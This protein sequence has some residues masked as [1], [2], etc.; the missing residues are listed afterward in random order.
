MVALVAAEARGSHLDLSTMTV[1][2]NNRI[3]RILISSS[4]DLA[5]P[6]LDIQKKIRKLAYDHRIE[7]DPFLWEEETK[8][9]LKLGHGTP[10]QI[11]INE[12]LSN[13][14]A[15]TVVMFGE[16]I[17][18]PLIGKLPEVPAG[19]LEYWK[20]L[21]LTHPWPKDV[22][23]RQSLLDQGRFPLT[24]TVYELLIA[25]G[26]DSDDE[27]NRRLFVGYVADMPI[28][29]ETE[30]GDIKFN[31]Y[32]HFNQSEK[33]ATG[34]LKYGKWQKEYTQQIHGIINLQKALIESDYGSVLLRFDE[35]EKM[36]NT[37]ASLVCDELIKRESDKNKEAILKPDFSHYSL[38]DIALPDRAELRKKLK[39]E[40]Y[41]SGE[42]GRMLALKGPSG[43]GKSSL[44]QR[45]V[46]A[47][48]PNE[49]R[50]PIVM[51]VRPTDL[52]T[53]TEATPLMRLLGAVAERLDAEGVQTLGPQRNPPGPDMGR[54]VAAAAEYLGERLEHS[55]RT[56]VLGMDQFE[57]VL[58]FA[59][60]D[61]KTQRNAAGSWWQVFRFL[62]K[63]VQHPKIWL[64]ATLESQRAERLN[65]M[66]IPDVTGL[67]F[68]T[69][70]VDFHFG[71]V[72][73]FVKD[74]AIKKSLTF[75]EELLDVIQ[76]MVEKFENS[77]LINKTDKG[78]NASF[79]PLL[80]LWLYRFFLK[81]E[82]KATN[83]KDASGGFNRST[84]QIT[85]QD[86]RDR[87]IEPDL[88]SLVSHLVQDAWAEASELIEQE[89]EPVPEVVDPAA[90]SK[91]IR[92]LWN[93][94]DDGKRL[95][96]HVTSER[97]IDVGRLVE[98]LEANNW[99]SVP[100]IEKRRPKR[101]IPDPISL[102]NFLMPL[103]RLDGDGNMQLTDMPA[104]SEVDSIERL[105][106]A[107]RRRRLLEPVGT[108]RVRLIHQAVIDHWP[109]GRDWFQTHTALFK[110]IRRLNIEVPDDGA[111]IDFTDLAGNDPALVQRAALILG[112]M[113]GVWASRHADQLSGPSAR[114]RSFC[115]ALVA[116]APD[117]AVC[118]D[119]DGDKVPLVVEAARYDLHEALDRWLTATPD[120]AGY[121]GKLGETL[122]FKAAWSAP[123]AVEALLKHK[124]DPLAP[125]EQK[126]HAITGAIQTGQTE[127]I[128]LLLPFYKT[129]AAVVGPNTMTLLHE[130]AR[131]SDSRVLDTLMSWDS[132]AGFDVKDTNGATPLHYAA[133]SGRK[134]QVDVLMGRSNRLAR[135]TNRLSALD[136]AVALGHV[137]VVRAILGHPDLTDDERTALLQGD[138][139]LR[140]SWY[141]PLVRAALVG[142]AETLR[143]LL[144]HCDPTDACHRDSGKHPLALMADQNNR[145]NLT[146][147]E[148]DRIGACTRILLDDGRLSADDALE[149]LKNC[150]HLPDVRR[151]IQDWL[152]LRGDLKNLPAQTLLSALTGP[153]ILI[154]NRILRV[155]KDVLDA[156]DENGRTGA[157]KLIWQGQ[158]ATIRTALSGKIAPQ[159]QPGLFRLEAAL[160]LLPK[161]KAA[162]SIEGIDTQTLHPI[163]RALLDNRDDS[164]GLK[165]T[166]LV[167]AIG[168]NKTSDIT[169]TNR[170]L[171]H[172]LAIRNE[173]E[174]FERVLAGLE[175][176]MPFD[177]YGRAP[178]AMAPPA[179]QEAFESMEQ[180][181]RA[182]IFR[183]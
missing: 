34:S 173:L 150:T 38:N 178:S 118:Y 169:T 153:N 179:R 142:K 135:E 7:V 159:E 51:A 31:N 149:A 106:A 10:V 15:M 62:G 161:D 160:R 74:L 119:I 53:R 113:R 114:L 43:C 93:N 3:P 50:N 83:D 101:W 55:N 115:L 13:N 71:I 111:T 60:M 56:F 145:E 19:M 170:S 18:A 78:K 37:L 46:L 133:I 45:G 126:F 98:I 167:P 14:L 139:E 44:L 162:K 152:L 40:L 39:T 129:S 23:K 8:D 65:E 84:T 54:R 100:G 42:D 166:A 165:L 148:A 4:R 67:Q 92:D 30:L 73:D 138:A 116:A 95:V 24:G 88:E 12:M 112:S 48:L 181:H 41:Q 52:S 117:G 33:P 121:T 63:A 180:A 128:G 49:F 82:D 146:A 9:G 104:T 140:T 103:V 6:R 105:I 58:D 11:Q 147:P 57:E 16:R 85:L 132:K 17:G 172:R 175:E 21:G 124:I 91:F 94:S 120:L 134:T 163:I 137:E 127:S 131:A 151:Q 154:A 77:K 29:S 123:K 108:N 87:N 130:A 99:K 86:M 69:V 90:F 28:E 89:G 25:L 144:R 168:E 1:T 72:K 125:N 136:V 96:S 107:H 76:S 27:E 47:E 66:A 177:R 79:L 20:G 176:P 61:E 59:S 22:S 70:D 68:K 164:I 122:L 32:N 143:E 36:V 155:R 97:G 183:Q 158:P 156:T 182:R 35:Q 157:S 102:D 171:L 109:P 81:F 26:L 110:D 174:A 5:I 2:Q 141:T 64:A 75:S 80:S